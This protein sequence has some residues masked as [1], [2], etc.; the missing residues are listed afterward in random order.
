MRSFVFIG[1]IGALFASTSIAQAH[2]TRSS[3]T[4]AKAETLV[5]YD[6][7]VPPLSAAERA[8]LLPELDRIVRLLGG[9]SLAA[10][11]LAAIADDA[12]GDWQP[13]L[14]FQQLLGRYVR[15][16]NQVRDGLTIDNAACR[17]SGAAMPGKRFKH[18]R[19]AV[20]SGV[21]EIPSVEVVYGDQEL[22]TLIEGP[23]RLIGPLE[24]ELDVH[25]IGKT[26]IAYRQIGK[27][28]TS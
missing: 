13:W 5:A 21:L 3:W 22:P 4:A 27:R 24:A 2:N 16:R 23:S 19:C 9:L 7:T 6:A 10:Y 11:D 15:A 20:T 17:G 18:F 28:R 12:D 25:V 1:L 26:S 14:T 8:A